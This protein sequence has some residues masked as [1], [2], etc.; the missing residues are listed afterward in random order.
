MISFLVDLE[1]TLGVFWD[2][3]LVM[4]ASGKRT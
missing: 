4:K 1:G 3:A 2:E